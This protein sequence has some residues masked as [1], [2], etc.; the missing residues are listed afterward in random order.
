MWN[1]LQ[2]WMPE[3]KK[4][5]SLK[6]PSHTTFFSLNLLLSGQPGL[7]VSLEE[8]KQAW[9]GRVRRKRSSDSSCWFGRCESPRPDVE[10]GC[11]SCP[12]SSLGRVEFWGGP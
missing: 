1:T 2:R 3:Q 10:V 7:L 9:E 6:V 12:V 5:T 11:T 4:S 8:G